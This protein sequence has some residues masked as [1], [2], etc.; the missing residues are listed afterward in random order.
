VLQGGLDRQLGKLMGLVEKCLAEKQQALRLDALCFVRTCLQLHAPASVQP[1][2][3]RLLDS[4]VTAAAGDWY[5][6]IAEALR[7]LTA[8]LPAL[9]PV[10]PATGRFDDSCATFRP[11]AQK[12]FKAVQPRLDALDIDHEIKECAILATGTLFS[13][14][15]D[16]LAPQLPAVLALFRRR[17][18]NETTRSS[19]LKALASMARSSLQLDLSGFLLQTAG[20]LALFLRQTSRSLKQLTL[21]T[22]EA[23]VASP[24]TQV[25]GSEAEVILSEVRIFAITRAGPLS[26]TVRV[27]HYV[28]RT[29]CGSD[30]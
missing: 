4:V 11:C 18:E 27:V 20:D 28:F 30:Q 19:T 12:V 5:K 16:E 25:A 7:V 17:L 26:L 8:M 15:G 21:Q 14:A 3:P 24:R 6:V 1:W 9:R 13:Y 10:D 29:G 2:A 23:I 22:L